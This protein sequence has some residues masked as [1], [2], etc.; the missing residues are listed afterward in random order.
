MQAAAH[1]DI[2]RGADLLANVERHR[3][4]FSDEL[5][6][7]RE[8]TVEY[9]SAS[10]SNR[11][12]GDSRALGFDDAAYVAMRDDARRT[13]LFARA[14]RERIAARRGARTTVLDLGT[15]PFAL[16]ALLAA[17]AGAT[18][19]GRSRRT[20]A[21]ARARASTCARGRRGRSR[22][23][24][25]RR[26]P[27]TAVA[28]RVDLPVCG[29]RRLGR[30]R[31]GHAGRRRD[32]ASGT[33]RGR[34][35]AWIPTAAATLVAPAVFLPHALT[36]GRLDGRPSRAPPMRCS[37]DRDVHQ[38]RRRGRRSSTARNTA[39]QGRTTR[40]AAG[41]RPATPSSRSRRTARAR[42]GRRGALAGGSG[43]AHADDDRCGCGR[44][45]AHALGRGAVA[46]ARPRRARRGRRAARSPAGGRRRT[47][48]AGKRRA[49]AGPS[50][51]SR[52]W[53]R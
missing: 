30:V 28:E 39:E 13:P 5:D 9:Y 25:D 50:S 8:H 52:H 7:G 44:R 45:R 14:I 20:R 10:R 35:R 41:G 4:G 46:G 6:F 48:T 29:P 26:G 11:N 38:P 37:R 2:G 24:R 31:G 27:T 53:P 17:E 34:E 12:A 51:S 18:K 49:L 3:R 22:S 23:R 33:S 43:D 42:G 47:A 21:R 19:S 16:L 40:V 15:G 1:L 32:A 36:A